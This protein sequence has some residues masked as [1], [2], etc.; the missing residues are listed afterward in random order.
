MKTIA[1]IL[2]AT[3]LV[4]SPD[5]LHAQ[6]AL[7]GSFNNDLAPVQPAQPDSIVQITAEAEGLSQVDPST[8][9][10]LHPAGGRCIRAAGRCR[11]L[12]RPKICPCRFTK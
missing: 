7:I 8:L 12:A 1:V 3:G 10:F 4:F 11:C 5:L 2:L 9:P 6:T